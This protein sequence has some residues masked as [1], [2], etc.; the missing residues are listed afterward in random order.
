MYMDKTSVLRGKSVLLL[1]SI[2]CLVIV[3]AY[4]KGIKAPTD[5]HLAAVNVMRRPDVMM[6]PAPIF[7]LGE[8]W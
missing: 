3:I 5:R 6:Q 7:Y 1:S 2:S 8:V 4:F